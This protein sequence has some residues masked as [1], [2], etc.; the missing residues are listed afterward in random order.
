MSHNRSAQPQ[1]TRMIPHSCRRVTRAREVSSAPFPERAANRRPRSRI[2]RLTH[3]NPSQYK[4]ANKNEVK[5]RKVVRIETNQNYKFVGGKGG[6]GNQ[7]IIYS[8]HII[9]TCLLWSQIEIVRVELGQSETSARTTRWSNTG[10][11]LFSIT[12]LRPTWRNKSNNT[13]WHFITDC[14]FKHKGEHDC[15]WK[16]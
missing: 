8:L 9:R 10:L 11:R 6:E 2:H 15:K 13:Y 5:E 16:L 1:W 3:R 12:P 7:T 4:H 14:S